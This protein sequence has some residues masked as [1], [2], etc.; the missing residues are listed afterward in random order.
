MKCACLRL[1]EAKPRAKDKAV[2][3]CARAAHTKGDTGRDPSTTSLA[4]VTLLALVRLYE[5]HAVRDGVE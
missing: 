5:S 2:R 1:I 4:K 3:C